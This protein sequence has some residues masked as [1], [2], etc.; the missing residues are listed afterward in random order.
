MSIDINLTFPFFFF[1][2]IHICMIFLKDKFNP[3]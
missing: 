1:L 3:K 2:F